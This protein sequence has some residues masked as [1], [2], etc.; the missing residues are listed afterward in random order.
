MNMLRTVAT[1]ARF[2]ARLLFRSWGFR[3]FSGTALLLLGLV[4]AGLALSPYSGLY[5]SRAL[6]GAF[7]VI[8]LKLLNVFQG[9]MAVFIA[10]EHQNRDRR[11]DTTE[12]VYVHPFANEAYVLGKFLGILAVFAALN[13]AVAFLA[14]LVQLVFSPAPFSAAAYLAALLLLNIPTLLFMIGLTILLGSLIRQSSVVILAS[15]VYAFLALILLG[16]RAGSVFDP[17]GFHLPFF[18]SD[19]IGLGNL[20]AVLPLRA[21][22]ALLGLGFASISMLL[23]RRLPQV[24][25]L[26]KAFV[27]LP[28]L[29]LSAAAWLFAAQLRGRA[30][31]RGFRD[32]IRAASLSAS[33]R[34]AMAL[35]RCDLR[36]KTEGHALSAAA[37]LVLSNPNGEAVRTI[38]LNLNPGLAVVS[39][40]SESG[41]L[42]FHRTR[43]LL[44]VEPSAPV[45]PGGAVNLR[46]AYGGKIDE[47]YCYLDLDEAGLETPLRL[48]LFPI[49]KRFAVVEPEFVHLTPESGW[50]PRPGLPQALLFPAPARADFIRFTLEVEAPPG[51]TAVS[52]GLPSVDRAG[53]RRIFRFQPAT[54]LPQISLTLGRFE[55]KSV[56]V[57]GIRYAL[58]LLEGHDRFTPKLA[59]IGPELPELIRQFR[60]GYEV[61]L[62]LKYPFELFALVEV[63]VH[64]TSH[65]RLWTTAQELVQ[66]QVIFLPEMGVFA[67][68]AEFRAGGGM[69]GGALGQ[70]AAGPRGMSQAGPK[71]MQ[72][73]QLNRFVLSNLTGMRRLA[74]GLRQAGPLGLRVENNSEASF[75]IFPNFLAF[76][77]RFA[78][79][80]WPLLDY[81]L[82]AYL[83]ERVSGQ[84][85]GPLL[86]IAQMLLPGGVSQESVNQY[87]LAHAL[88][89]AVRSSG[90]SEFPLAA[91]IEEKGKYLWTYIRAVLGR[92]DFDE[93]LLGFLSERRFRPI[94]RQSL[95]AFVAG[96]GTLDLGKTIAAWYEE[97][98][99]AG[100]IVENIQSYRVV[101]GEKTKFQVRFQVSNPTD[102]QGVLKVSWVTRGGFGMRG[103]GGGI[104]GLAA[105]IPSE[106]RTVIVPAMTVKEVGIVLDQA[107]VTTTID[108]TMSRNLPPVFTLPFGS[109]ATPPGAKPFD[110]EAAR[111]YRQASPGENGEYIV[112]NEDA[113]F[114][115]PKKG[116][117]NWL[118]RSVRRVFAADSEEDP[119]T[120][121]GLAE[122]PDDWQPV[123]LQNFYGRF[124]RSAVVKKSGAGAKRV[125]WSANLAEP[126]TYDLSFHFEGI[127][128]S[129]GRGL[130][131]AGM[132]GQRG[133]GPQ[134][135]GQRP[136]GPPGGGET[137]A[138]G[139]GGA[140]ARP[141]SKHFIVH[142]EDG[143]EEIVIDLK[144]ARP[145]W[146]P[147]GSFRFAA[148]ESLI[149]LTDKND[150]RFVLADAV[151]W[152]RRS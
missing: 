1:V 46:L 42:P 35:E 94:P 8:V 70:T 13:L 151:K 55:S 15:L 136:S 23:L 2:E 145:G 53:E 134:E 93:R 26:R 3:F 132:R 47:R 126:G 43:H 103:G 41:A 87:L 22:Y 101:E 34:P 11:L 77:S 66:P 148:G 118:R 119:M 114:K 29:A 91:V 62:G 128:G 92:S 63:P 117:E 57:D 28:L 54:P 79:P 139:R 111:P 4:A 135:G 72:R 115:L 61:N 127:G 84:A 131:M 81:A 17:F 59:E 67:M 65:P 73:A 56:D 102:R 37:D 76:A 116:R 45:P 125:A 98:G 96:L 38:L 100:F 147:I 149:E 16:P 78:I 97:K 21:A 74:A 112:D 124:V 7:P 82:E 129:M 146:T 27:V 152:V 104:M 18:P 85:A 140:L 130:G 123:V 25:R 120:L 141:G 105:S 90:R 109:Q 60:D 88:S 83:R 121:M 40:E 20:P 86:R 10:V 44:E 143:V 50:Y 110:G 68:G 49:P 24:S 52:Q 107:A 71:A 12:V 106:S 95:E 80:E 6:S 133:G 51:L 75:D 39:V 48:W 142:A 69:F 144:D 64:V 14:A 30:A 5:F 36:L 138:Q 108:T 9:I 113:G 99:L 31:D 137:P 150:G 122:P 32:E 33:G 19:F 58:H 89:E